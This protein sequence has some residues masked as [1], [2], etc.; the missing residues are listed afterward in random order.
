MELIAENTSISVF[1]VYC[2]FVHKHQAYTVM[3]RV[4]DKSCMPYGAH[5]PRS[6]DKIC[7]GNKLKRIFDELR[8]LKPP[9]G[10]V[11]QSYM[12]GS[13]HDS[14]IPHCLTRFGPFKTIQDFRLWLRGGHRLSSTE[15]KQDH[16]DWR[17]IKEMATKQ[18]GHWPPPV[19]THGDLNPNNTFVPNDNIVG[20][21]DWEF[22]GWYPNYWEYT[23]ACYGNKLRP[24]WQNVLD[25]FLQPYSDEHEM[26]ITRQ[27]WWGDF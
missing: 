7:F 10:V 6:L 12:G 5:C 26:E 17:K 19:F 8:A 13:L 24:Y 18:D 23:S 21:I 27:K 11:V 2:S 9:K 4:R 15:E 22:S 20:I 25:Q 14:G 1:N 3:D 16:Q